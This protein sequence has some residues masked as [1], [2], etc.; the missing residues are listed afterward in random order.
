MLDL[1]VGYYGFGKRQ[2]MP[3]LLEHE[4][5]KRIA[6]FSQMA[7]AGRYAPG[8]EQQMLQKIYCS[9]VDAVVERMAVSLLTENYHNSLMAAVGL[10]AALIQMVRRDSSLELE[11][12]ASAV[13]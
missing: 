6:T 7:F 3:M 4:E 9:K 13:Y 2:T 1:P 8:L 5:R 10:A 11:L 12:E